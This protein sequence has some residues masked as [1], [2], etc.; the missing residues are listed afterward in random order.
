MDKWT[1]FM[2]AYNCYTVVV[3]VGLLVELLLKL[4]VFDLRSGRNA[5]V[6]CALASWTRENTDCT[7]PGWRAVLLTVETILREVEWK[8]FFCCLLICCRT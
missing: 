1:A 5:S 4:S 7:P 8:L 6:H 3:N 2:L